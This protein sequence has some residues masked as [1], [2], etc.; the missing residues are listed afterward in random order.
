[1]TFADGIADDDLYLLLGVT[2]S[3]KPAEVKR[4]YRQQAKRWHPDQNKL[5][6]EATARMAAINRAFEILKDP[7]TREHYDETLRT[8]E[9][10]PDS[11]DQPEPKPGPQH[12]P[13]GT[14]S[15]KGKTRANSYARAASLIGYFSALKLEVIDKRAKGGALWVVGGQELVPTME[16]LRQE[17][18][19]FEFA[20]AG[21][22][23]TKHRPAW[24]SESPA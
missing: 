21:G 2:V 14:R 23:A 10:P 18:F 1:M 12:S 13:E 15:Y 3:A 19:A 9:E 11:A 20:P 16:R 24:W 17:G 6:P 4:G 22:R 5:H 7:A 8:A